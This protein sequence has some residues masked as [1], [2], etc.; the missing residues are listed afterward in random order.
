MRR[1]VPRDKGRRPREQHVQAPAAALVPAP[2]DTRLFKHAHV[3]APTAFFSHHVSNTNCHTH[4]GTVPDLCSESGLY[5]LAEELKIAVNADGRVAEDAPSAVTCLGRPKMQ[6][7]TAGRTTTREERCSGLEP[8]ELRLTRAEFE[9]ACAALLRRSLVPVLDVLDGIGIKPDE[10]DEVVLVGG[11]SR[12]PAIRR[13]VAEHFGVE[14]GQLNT[15]IDPDRVV[16]IGC[17]SVIV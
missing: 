11:S 9:G 2:A 1:L 16:A 10:V 7:P 13:T 5:I 8:M 14:V 6:A 3:Q 12:I 17:A 15:D 4:A